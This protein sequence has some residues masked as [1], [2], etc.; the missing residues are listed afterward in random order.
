MFLMVFFLFTQVQTAVR[1]KEVVAITGL[2]RTTVYELLRRGEIPSI[3]VGRA[4]LVPV[5]ALKQWVEERTT[6]RELKEE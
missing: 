5:A 6:G 2:G 1:A 4:V 3:R